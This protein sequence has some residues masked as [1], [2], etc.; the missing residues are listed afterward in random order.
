[1][2]VAGVYVYLRAF[3]D[4]FL[5]IYIVHW[6]GKVIRFIYAKCCVEFS[7]ILMSD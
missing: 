6:R 2:M 1:M 7:Q 5:W 4:Y 3:N